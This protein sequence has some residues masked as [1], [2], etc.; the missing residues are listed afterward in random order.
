M[1]AKGITLLQ[2]L[3]FDGKRKQSHKNNAIIKMNTM[4]YVEN[5]K[6]KNHRFSLRLGESFTMMESAKGYKALGTPDYANLSHTT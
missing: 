3:I 4:I 5:L 2:D 6:G 1:L